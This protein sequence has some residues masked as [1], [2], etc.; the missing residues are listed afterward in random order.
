M[1][2]RYEIEKFPIQV[3]IDEM[4][5]RIHELR[6]TVTVKP[7]DIKKLQLRLQ[8]RYYLLNVYHVVRCFWNKLD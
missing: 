7:T 4:N 2:A 5:Q 8:V 6:Q 1:C 3:A